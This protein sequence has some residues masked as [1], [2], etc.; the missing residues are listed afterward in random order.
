MECFNNMV[1]VIGVFVG[2]IEVIFEIIKDLLKLILGI[3]VV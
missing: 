2:G 3:V 1:I